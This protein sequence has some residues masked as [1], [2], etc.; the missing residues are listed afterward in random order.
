M[1]PH[2]L[3][4][5]ANSTSLITIHYLINLI[6]QLVYLQNPMIPLAPWEGFID[7]IRKFAA[8][9]RVNRCSFN[10]LMLI[11]TDPFGLLRILHW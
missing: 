4:S 2:K 1:I 6:D 5:L 3:I 10:Y 11:K 8:A 7:F 9:L